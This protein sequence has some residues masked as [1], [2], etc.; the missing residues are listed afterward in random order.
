MSAQPELFNI[1]VAEYL[2]L[3]LDSNIRHE[4]IAGQVYAMTGGSREHDQIIV[5]ILTRLRTD[6]RGSGCRVFSSNMK[7]RIEVLDLFYYPDISVTCDPQDREKYFNRRPCLIVE[8][9]SPSTTRID[10]NEKLHNY[11]QLESLREYVLVSQTEMK[12][13]IYRKDQSGNWNLQTLNAGDMM[14]LES[15]GVAMAI[16]EIYEDVEF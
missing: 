14:E 1:P 3:E 5:N 10:R 6:L 7:V 15:V 8:V 2:K 13:E 4:Y 9:L 11:R 16:A 12:V